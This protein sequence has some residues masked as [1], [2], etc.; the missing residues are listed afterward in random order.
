[1][2]VAVNRL[3]DVYGKLASILHRPEVFG[4]GESVPQPLALALEGTLQTLGQI[5]FEEEEPSAEEDLEQE[6]SQDADYSV[7]VVN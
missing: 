4:L 6:L 5:I 7:S 3:H 1:M 2:K